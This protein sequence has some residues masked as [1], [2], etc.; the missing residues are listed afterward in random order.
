MPQLMRPQRSGAGVGRIAGLV[1]GPLAVHVW[2]G[3]YARITLSAYWGRFGF[4][5]D[6]GEPE[7]S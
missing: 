4:T 7:A 3:T 2:T 5:L 6:F 1:W